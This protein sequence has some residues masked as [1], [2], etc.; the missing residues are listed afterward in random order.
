ML[1]VLPPTNQTCLATNLPFVT[2]SVHT[3]R[4]TG[5]SQ[6][7]F[8]VSEVNPMSGVTL[9]RF[10]PSRSQYSL[11]LTWFV[12]IQAWTCVVKRAISPFNSFC[13]NVAIQAWTCVVK[14]AISPFNSFCNNVAI[15]AWTCVVK[16]ATSL[17]N[18]CCN[19]VAKQ[20]ARVLSFLPR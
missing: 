4:F 17:F 8:A 13:N 9:A 18:S 19:N 5:P 7:R 12:A 11:N 14:R 15:Q 1:C 10:Y 16:R 6:T 2:K 20:V 3:A